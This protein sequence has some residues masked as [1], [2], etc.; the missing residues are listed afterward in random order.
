MTFLQEYDAF[1]PE[2]SLGKAGLFFKHLRMDWRGLFTELRD[3]RPILDLSPFVVGCAD[4]TAVLARPSVFQVTYR[5]HMD[6]SVG[7]FILGRDNTKLDWHDKSLMRA[8]LR[9]EDLPTIRSFAGRTATAALATPD[10]EIDVVR[11]VSRLV[12]LR[13]VEQCFGFY[14]P[15]D[16]AMLR[17]SWATQADMFHNLT[18]DAGLLAANI[19]ADSEMRTWLRCFLARRQPWA[20]ASGDDTV[21]RL[22]RLAASDAAGLNL[23]GVVSNVAGLLVGA[24]ET[25]SQAIVNA[26]EQ[27]LL[28]P[29]VKAAA[30][31]AA[32]SEDT[33]AFDAI[34]W[35]ALRF[36]PM[37]TFVLRIATEPSV[38]APGSDHETPV[39]SGRVVAAAI[40]SA[41]FDPAI[42]PEPDDFK[43]RPRTDYLHMGF[44]HHECL[45]QYVGYTMIPETVRQILLLPGV[46]LLDGNGSA[47]DNANGPFAERFIIGYSPEQVH[48]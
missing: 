45:G 15:D 24:I 41:M 7:P 30:I 25:T 31:A 39:A 40:G 2:D 12:P 42:F 22:L 8:L 29:N 35:E 26:T 46:H 13:V 32:L 4:V 16:A 5:P 37:T 28:R 34:V 9:W 43:A 47:V 33:S 27:I 36:N 1:G 18:S 38:L 11:R 21:S 14:G 17:W 20:L 44:G 3:S 10:K 6:P 19:A 48:G 23:E